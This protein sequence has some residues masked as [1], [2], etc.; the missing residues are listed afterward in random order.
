MF[1]RLPAGTLAGLFALATGTAAGSLAPSREDSAHV[2][3]DYS[4][5][6]TPQRDGARGST[7]GIATQAAATTFRIHRS[8]MAVTPCPPAA[9]IDTSPRPDPCSDNSFARVPTILPPVAANG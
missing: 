4:M 2:A 7:T 5:S 1:R 3:Y 9:Q 6:A 8:M